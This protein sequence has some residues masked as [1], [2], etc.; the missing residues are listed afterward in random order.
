MSSVKESGLQSAALG[1]IS[2]FA[3]IAGL[4]GQINPVVRE[5][6][7]IEQ[8]KGALRLV[9]L[10]LAIASSSAGLA[11]SLDG[12]KK[13]KLERDRF[14]VNREL[15]R[16]ELETSGMIGI[17]AKAEAHKWLEELKAKAFAAEEIH[18]LG[19]SEIAIASAE[20]ERQAL[21]PQP[22]PQQ[23]PP[24]QAQQPAVNPLP[25]ANQPIQQQ[26][27][28]GISAIAPVPTL[29]NGTPAP[30][31]RRSGKYEW[32]REWENSGTILNYGGQGSGKTGKNNYLI[33]HHHAQ[34]AE[35]WVFDPHA[36]YG[37]YPEFCKVFGGGMNYDEINTAMCEFVDEV[38]DRYEK[39]H[40]IPG[41]AESIY[42]QTKRIVLF[43]EE[44]Q[45]WCS[46]VNDD[47]LEKFV[48]KVLTSTRKANMGVVI[49]SQSGSVTSW[50]G[51]AAR[52]NK[53]L[54]EMSVGKL[55]GIPKTDPSVPGGLRP[56]A[57]AW[58]KPSG[59]ADKDRIQVSYPDWIR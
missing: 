5:D 13:Q 9:S 37:Q 6:G 29:S 48:G 33:K 24:Q 55:E 49:T 1:V 8:G 3:L 35:I 2:T 44:M 21:T 10:V 40:S 28:S 30:V 32:V 23:L 43:C 27:V 25:P 12:S 54:V 19:M 18:K 41:Y 36:A 16:I 51:K 47:I 52:G 34:G 39:R 17:E 22:M 31:D 15:Q 38:L 50:L 57:I 42:T 53:E 46:N 4:S 14:E 58:W 7:T 59:K 11:I 20:S 56:D 45:D 26:P